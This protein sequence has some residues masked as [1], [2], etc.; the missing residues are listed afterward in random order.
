MTHPLSKDNGGRLVGQ[1]EISHPVARTPSI[2]VLASDEPDDADPLSPV[3]GLDG[4]LSPKGNVMFQAHDKAEYQ[5][6]GA[7][8]SSASLS[9]QRQSR[10]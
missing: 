3:D 9:A 10:G 6:L 8:I 1:C 4:V 2:N 5:P 7:R